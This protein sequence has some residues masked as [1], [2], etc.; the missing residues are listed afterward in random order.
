MSSHSDS[1][2]LRSYRRWYCP[3]IC[4]RTETKGLAVAGER[5]LSTLKRYRELYSK[6]NRKERSRL[7]D[8]FCE[9]TQYHRKYAISLLGKLGGVRYAVL[10]KIWDAAG[11]PWSKRLKAMLPQWLPWARGRFALLTPAVEAQ[12]LAMSARQRGIVHQCG[13]DTGGTR[14]SPLWFLALIGDHYAV[15]FPVGGMQPRMIANGR[16]YV[17]STPP[18]PY[19]PTASKA[20]LYTNAGK[21]SAVRGIPPWGMLL[22]GAAPVPPRLMISQVNGI[23]LSWRFAFTIP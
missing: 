19:G 12:L 18:G 22:P 2:R 3:A 6:A 7:L 11:H 10:E 5:T 20:K 15:P 4:D 9:L 14:D 1:R 23:R 17:A 8:E 21:M 13:Q 16:E